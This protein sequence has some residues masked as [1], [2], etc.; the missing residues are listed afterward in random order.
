[1]PSKSA[2]FIYACQQQMKKTPHRPL[3]L[4]IIC[5]TRA[6]PWLDYSSVCAPFQTVTEGAVI[7]TKAGCRRIREVIVVIGDRFICT[8][9]WAIL[10]VLQQGTKV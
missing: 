4:P 10:S 3:T 9:A 7:E 1:M 8:S 5:L 6:S 2:R